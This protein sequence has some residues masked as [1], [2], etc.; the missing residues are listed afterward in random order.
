MVAAPLIVE[1]VLKSIQAIAGFENADMAFMTETI[2][3]ISKDLPIMGSALSETAQMMAKADID[4][5]KIFGISRLS[6][7]KCTTRAFSML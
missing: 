6:L 1:D 4:Y 3:T 7:S 5:E 2:K